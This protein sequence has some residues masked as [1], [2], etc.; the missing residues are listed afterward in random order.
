MSKKRIITVDSFLNDWKDSGDA[1]YA[2]GS[3]KYGIY[4]YWNGNIYSRSDEFDKESIYN[5]DAN[6]AVEIDNCFKFAGDYD[7]VSEYG[8]LVPDPKPEYYEIVPRGRVLLKAS[9]SGELNEAIILVPKG[10][11]DNDSMIKS[12]VRK[13]NLSSFQSI[14]VEDDEREYDTGAAHYDVFATA[15]AQHL[16]ESLEYLTE[17]LSKVVEGFDKDI[18]GISREVFKEIL[19]NPNP[20]G[21][22]L[23]L[24]KY[25]YELPI[26]EINI[27]SI[28]KIARGAYDDV[29]NL[30]KTI[31]P[32]API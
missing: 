21:E 4:F 6:I 5:P 11:E 19:I 18:N 25:D 14:S 16:W 20:G 13:F 10:S 27:G 30:V 23:E 26:E 2:S 28:G 29:V 1:L 3:S 22:L 12:I 32:I 31:Y 15:Q 17:L 9:K 24:L 8:R 7:H